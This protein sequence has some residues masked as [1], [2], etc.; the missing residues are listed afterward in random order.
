MHSRK[1][2]TLWPWA[3]GAP[4]QHRSVNR[5]H[6]KSLDIDQAM[7]LLQLQPAPL[8][9]TPLLLPSAQN[10]A[11]P[12][13]IC[14]QLHKRWESG[15]IYSNVGSVL[16]AVNPYRTIFEK[17]DDGRKVRRAAYRCLLPCASV[18]PDAWFACL[19][20]SIYSDDV[21]LGYY[22]LEYTLAVEPHVFGVAANAY[23]NL[24][25]TR[26]PQCIVISGDSGAGKTETAKQVMHYL[27]VVDAQVRQQDTDDAMRRASVG[28]PMET[29]VVNQD[30]QDVSSVVVQ[31]LESNVSASPCVAFDASRV[32]CH[33]R[34]AGRR[35]Y[36]TA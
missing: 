8:L 35:R 22:E 5:K 14:D 20:E 32:P 23:R 6:S 2:L 1:L 27:A 34:Y 28:M 21:A 31:L 29:V 7:M 12:G 18:A 4:R 36:T 33:S 3:P 10:S 24:V 16:I 11:D 25:T 26:S 19:Q 17:K 13:A 9:P 30:G 15:R